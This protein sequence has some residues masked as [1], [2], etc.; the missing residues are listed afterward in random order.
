VE[1]SSPIAATVVACSV[2]A[3][4]VMDIRTLRVP[5]RVTLPL[6]AAGILYHAVTAG[7]GGLL[8]SLLGAL[9][10]FGILF[11]LYV[12]GIMGS[13]DVKLLAGVGAWLGPLSTTYVFVIAALAT[14]AYSLVVL[15]SRGNLSGAIIAIRMTML[16]LQTIAR[17]LGADERVGINAGREDSRKRF[18]PF[19]AMMA[20]AVIGILIWEWYP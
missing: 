11:G 13:G 15:L 3:A 4:G 16:Q 6:L 1:I 5:N 9:V 17:H 7:L 18:V 2:A 14:A 19:A 12:L 8:V 20:L 10:G